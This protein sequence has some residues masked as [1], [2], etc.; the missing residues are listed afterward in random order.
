MEGDNPL[1][2]S[3]LTRFGDSFITLTHLPFMSPV[4]YL[5]RFILLLRRD[6]AA[7]VILWSALLNVE[8][9]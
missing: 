2:V 5:A 9:L 8:P 6:K 3:L 4:F 7:Y 1:V